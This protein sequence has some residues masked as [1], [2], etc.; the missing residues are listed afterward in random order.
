LHFKIDPATGRRT[1][2][3]CDQQDELYEHVLDLTN[4]KSN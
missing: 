3:K 1:I 4:H 2:G